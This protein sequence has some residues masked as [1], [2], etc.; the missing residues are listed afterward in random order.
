MQPGQVFGRIRVSVGSGFQKQ[1]R[2][3]HPMKSYDKVP[4]FLASCAVAALMVLPVACGGSSQPAAAP[5]DT[6]LLDQPDEKTAAPSSAAVQQG[7][8]ALKA[9]DIEKAKQILGDAHQKDP[10]DPQAAFYYAVALDNAGDIDGAIAGYKEA[11][12]LEPNLLEA[13]QN[14]SAALVDKKDFKG[15]LEV[16]DPGLKQNPDDPMLLLN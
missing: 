15:A 7:I 1:G 2:E 11:L 12:T 8:D 5:D 9:G 3:R 16:A 14:L 13:R 4:R 6:A 10:Q